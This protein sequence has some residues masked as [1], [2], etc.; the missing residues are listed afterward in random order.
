MTGFYMIRAFAEWFFRTHY[1]I[2]FILLKIR[3][4]RFKLAI[5]LTKF[6]TKLSEADSERCSTKL[7]ASPN[8][9]SCDKFGLK[10][11]KKL[12]LLYKI[13]PS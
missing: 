4:F 13:N 7:G 5:V 6:S 2:Y 3:S 9:I 10:F 8:N 1:N 11:W 12:T